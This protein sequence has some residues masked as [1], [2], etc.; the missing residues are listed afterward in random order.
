MKTP[1]R[2][3]FMSEWSWASK[4]GLDPLNGFN[5]IRSMPSKTFVRYDFLGNAMLDLPQ[6]SRVQS[7]LAG[8]LLS[9]STLH[10][11]VL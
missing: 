6:L 3:I 9:Y 1:L 8:W 4:L 2:V 10:Q 5:I 11:K 7:S